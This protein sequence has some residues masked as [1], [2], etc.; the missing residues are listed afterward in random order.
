MGPFIHSVPDP[1]CYNL[2]PQFWLCR[3]RFLSDF[4]PPLCFLD[5]LEWRPCLVPCCTTSAFF[6]YIPIL[7]FFPED[8]W[9][10]RSSRV[11][12]YLNLSTFACL[13]VTSL[14]NFK[15]QVRQLCLMDEFHSKW[16][17]DAMETQPCSTLDQGPA[18]S[19]LWP[20]L[21]H[22]CLCK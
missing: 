21:P 13:P 2:A 20:I 19:C 7:P 9:D 17:S 10:S 12:R 5:E 14:L 15:L 3:G 22:A 6:L 16:D 1:E 11:S 4:P 8:S 18:N